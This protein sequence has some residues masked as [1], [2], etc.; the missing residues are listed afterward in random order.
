[1]GRTLTR[2][3]LN[4]AAIDFIEIEVSSSRFDLTYE[5][6]HFTSRAHSNS[7][8]FAASISNVPSLEETEQLN[9]ISNQMSQIKEGQGAPMVS[10]RMNPGGG[11][12]DEQLRLSK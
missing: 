4:M 9:N 1:M 5:T 10:A 8:D 11:R 2:E 12:D 6:S 3:L 7:Y